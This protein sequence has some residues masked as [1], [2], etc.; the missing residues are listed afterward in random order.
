MPDVIAPVREPVVGAEAAGVDDPAAGERDVSEAG[1][2]FG[3]GAPSVALRA[4]A[5]VELPDE[6]AADPA[7]VDAGGARVVAGADVV[8]AAAVEGDVVAGADVAGAD[9]I[10][11]SEGGGPLGSGAPTVALPE[12]PVPLL[13]P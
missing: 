2:P 7:G 10:G 4:P 8:G 13:A 9:V 3:S 6:L 1:G 12:P 11:A 5:A